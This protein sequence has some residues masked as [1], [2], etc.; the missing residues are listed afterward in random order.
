VRGIAVFR[1]IILVSENIFIWNAFLSRCAKAPPQSARKTP[2]PAR[3]FF[4][5]FLFRIFFEWRK[6]PN[7]EAARSVRL[8]PLSF[9]KAAV[10][11]DFPPAKIFC[12]LCASGA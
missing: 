5:R 6:R 1:K 11:V 10:P 8:A 7:W 12:A 9:K 3:G 4:L 2:P